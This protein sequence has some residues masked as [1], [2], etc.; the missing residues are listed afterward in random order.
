MADD[1]MDYFEHQRKLLD[2][3]N[4]E[5]I[6]LAKKKRQLEVLDETLEKIKKLED[7]KKV[8]VSFINF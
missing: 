5:F 8:I 7:Q 2:T 6:E 1:G 3:Y 4:M